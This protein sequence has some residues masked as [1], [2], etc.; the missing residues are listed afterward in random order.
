MGNANDRADAQACHASMELIEIDQTLQCVVEIA[1]IV[2]AGGRTQG[3]PDR[4]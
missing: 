4:R 3:Y 1:L 2:E